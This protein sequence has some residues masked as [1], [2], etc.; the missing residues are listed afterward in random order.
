MAR[1]T[2]GT[3]ACALVTE[4]T[5]HTVISVEPV[6]IERTDHQPCRWTYKHYFYL[7]QKKIHLKKFQFQKKWTISLGRT[8]YLSI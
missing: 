1:H 5:D 8:S 4:Q 7:I 3:I 6:V 2:R